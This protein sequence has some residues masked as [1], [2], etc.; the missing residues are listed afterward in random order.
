MRQDVRTGERSSRGQLPARDK[1][2][3]GQSL[4]ELSLVIP[5]LLMVTIGTVDFGRIMYAYVTVVNAANTAAQYA[6]TST[7]A[8]ADTA[9]INA[10]A[11][12][13]AAAL[14]PQPAVIISSPTDDGQGD[15]F[16]QI[17]VSVLYTF[18][19]IFPAPLGLSPEIPI[20]HTTTMR[21]V[22]KS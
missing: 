6:A 20:S 22:P 11:L 12:N 9:G 21:V 16:K 14:I 4:V 1:G 15:G 7:I 3:Q 18:T 17:T 13:D 19:L 5:V 10:V 8:S 2:Q